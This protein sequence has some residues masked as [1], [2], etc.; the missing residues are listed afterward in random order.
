VAWAYS[1]YL[2]AGRLD[3]ARALIDAALA[4]NPSDGGMILA[5]S[6]LLAM[7]GRH[8]EALALLKPVAADAAL[9]RTFHHGTY[10]RACIYALGNDGKTSVEWL[11]RTVETGMPNYPAFAHDKCFDPIRS[12]APFTQFMA[13]L[14]PVWDGYERKMQYTPPQAVTR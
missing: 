5:R 8:A 7:Q 9:S 10:Q 13:R 4:R 2:G 12:S 11:E 6:R 3:E 14:K 1:F